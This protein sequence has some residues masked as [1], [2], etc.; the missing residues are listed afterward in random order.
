MSE[1]NE[2]KESLNKNYKVPKLRFPE[3]KDDWKITLIE[4][5]C[6]NE[7]YSFTG[8]PFGSNLKVSDYTQSGVRVIQLNNI[9]DI[10]FND[11]NK[12]FVSVKKADSLKSCN[13]Y[14]GDL[15]FA[16]MMPAGRLCILPK[17][18]DRYL[19]GS[20][21]IRLKPNI[22]KYYCFFLLECLNRTII[23]N[24]ITSKTSGS[25]RQRIGLSDLKKTSFYCPNYIEQKQIGLFFELIE[26]K[27]SII[28]KKINILKKYKE[29]IINLCFSKGKKY[30]LLS[31]IH[32]IDRRNKLNENLYVYSISNKKGFISQEE[33]FDGN[34]IASINKKRYKIV[35]K[36]EFAYNP[37][38]INVGSIAYLQE[39]KCQISPM[40]IVF[41]AKE[42]CNILL[43]EYFHSKYFKI[44][45]MT[46]LEGSVRKSLSFNSLCDFEIKI[47]EF[48]NQYEHI[49]QMLNNKLH[50]LEECFFRLQK[51][52]NYLLKLMFI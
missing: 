16:K 9:N 52:K 38:R 5:I 11:D 30:K 17:T 24:S 35:K 2:I 27:I 3:F 23:R 31:F 33:Q 8:G 6:T 40:Y 10:Y 41:S 25:T 43:N 47:N 20:D 13:A 50:I 7:K 44:E 49:F 18:Y 42:I 22:D 34:E 15:I 28:S 21:A 14:S 19:L 4:D 1:N 37:A 26:S 46:H 29:G 39:N 45:L 32:Q 48:N 12:V 51:T 36:D